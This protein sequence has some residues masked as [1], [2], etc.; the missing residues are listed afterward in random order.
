METEPFEDA[1]KNSSFQNKDDEEFL[2]WKKERSD[3]PDSLIAKFLDQFKIKSSLIKIFNQKTSIKITNELMDAIIL[4]S[5]LGFIFYQSGILKFE[6]SSQV[7]VLGIIGISASLEFIATNTP[8]FK[9]YLGRDIKTKVFLEKVPSM[10][11]AAIKDEIDLQNFSSKC[12]NFFLESI[13]RDGNKYSPYFIELVIS[14]QVLRKENLDIF[15][16]TQ[17]LKNILPNIIIKVLVENRDSLSIEN[18]QNVYNLDN[19][20]E[21]IIKI[22]I[23]TQSI[24]YYLIKKNPTDNQLPYFYTKY[25]LNKEHLDWKLNIIPL[26]KFRAI[27]KYSLVVLFIL[28]YSYYITQGYVKVDDFKTIFV[29]FVASTFVSGGITGFFG[30]FIKKLR[31]YYYNHLIKNII[32]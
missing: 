2:A 7:V 9:R 16:S 23:A 24:S 6:F 32:K 27:L 10:T 29:G 12:M 3:K 18:V 14:T 26:S 4:F 13:G 25:Q 5:F 11:K 19:K 28:I 30:Y 20:D 15:F 31:N 22:L 8:F 1:L 21:K 17:V